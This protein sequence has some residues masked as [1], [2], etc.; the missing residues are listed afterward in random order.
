MSIFIV[1][2]ANKIHHVNSVFDTNAGPNVIRKRRFQGRKAKICTGEQP[3]GKV[4]AVGTVTLHARMGV[5][6][7]RVVFGLVCNLAVSAL[8]GNSFI[9]RFLMGFPPERKIVLYNYNPVLI[10]A[11]NN[12]PKRTKGQG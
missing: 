2:L 1:L 4:S 9:D 11:I 8:L 5:S 6:R 12:L 7:V 3:T 10:L